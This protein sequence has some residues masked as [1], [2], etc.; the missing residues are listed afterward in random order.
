MST[1]DDEKLAR[2]LQ[3]QYENQAQRRSQRVPSRSR[4]SSV[5]ASGGGA[6][7]SSSESSADGASGGKRP[8]PRRGRKPKP[9]DI[10]DSN[11][12]SAAAATNKRGRST[13]KIAESDTTNDAELARRIT[14]KE[15]KRARGERSS[16]RRTASVERSRSM[17]RSSHHRSTTPTPPAPAAESANT[18]N[19]GEIAKRLAEKEERRARGERSSHRRT[20]S[21]EPSRIAGMDRSG[22]RRNR[23]ASVERSR[24]MERSSHRRTPPPEEKKE[25]PAIAND[26]EIA[27]RLAEKEERRSRGERSSHRRTASVGPSRS[28]SMDRS[29][30]RERS[31][32]RRSPP[33]EEKK[34]EEVPDTSNDADFAKRLAEKE[35]RRARGERSSHRRT[36]S[37]DTPSSPAAVAVDTSKDAALARRLS[38]RDMSGAKSKRRIVPADELE[39]VSSPPTTATSPAKNDVD[40]DEALAR[41]LEQ[42]M[43]DEEMALR[44]NEEEA[45]RRRRSTHLARKKAAQRARKNKADGAAAETSSGN[46]PSSLRA[47]EPPNVDVLSNKSNDKSTSRGRSSNRSSNQRSASKPRQR[48]RSRDS[49]D[50]DANPQERSRGQSNRNRKGS[51]SKSR[52]KSRSR[53]RSP[54][55]MEQA[56]LIL[57][58]HEESDRDLALKIDQEAR[59]EALARSLNKREARRVAVYQVEVAETTRG[60]N[61]WNCRRV[62]SLAIP[63]VVI[64]GAVVGLAFAFTGAGGGPS[65]PGLPTFQDEDPFNGAT[66]D[67]ANR[68][69]RTDGLDLDVLNALESQWNTNFDIAV[70]EWNVGADALDL[71]VFTV[72]V[73]NRCS[74]VNG[75]LKVCNGDYGETKWRG[76]NQVILSDGF[77]ISSIAKLNEYYLASADEAQRQYTMCHEIGHGFGL[78]HT[79]ENFFNADLGNCMDYTSNPEVNKS[80]DESNFS[81]LMDLY[82]PVGGRGRRK[83]RARRKETAPREYPDEPADLRLRIDE[84]VRELENEELFTNGKFKAK[85]LHSSEF[86]EAVRIDLGD[87]YELQVSKLLALP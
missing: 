46:Q 39:A 11:H 62:M 76:I 25:D 5:D 40:D 18:T 34:V 77:I 82:G 20:A 7:G 73:D 72:N 75:K 64:L 51:R 27:R 2:A 9:V 23:A 29:G 60:R 66:P 28:A 33:A 41:K 26:A 38:Q 49:Y 43:R 10:S 56:P 87:G 81:F 1:D 68:W 65:F 3:K 22:H 13:R 6:G 30:H 37:T 79:D 54:M 15:E 31:S 57:D 58:L 69:R 50:G 67:E 42:E 45:K 84:A 80:P 71:A 74:E 16:H 47:P 83:L 48:S 44:L 59:D 52:S 35:E 86:S 17:E 36:T 21:V 8:P 19:D 85:L 63:V 12:E 78:P 32:H 24:S 53:S 14:E 61:S 70:S 55:R 4:A